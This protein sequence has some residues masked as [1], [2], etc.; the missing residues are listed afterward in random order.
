MA[1]VCQRRW[2]FSCELAQMMLGRRNNGR[3]GVSLWSLCSTAVRCCVGWEHDFL[4][5]RRCC[6]TEI[7]GWQMNS[8]VVQTPHLS[9]GNREVGLAVLGYS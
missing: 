4:I 1:R 6:N 5:T 2:L 9:R 3:V 8:M 7:R